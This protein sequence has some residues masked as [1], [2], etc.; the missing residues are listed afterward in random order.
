MECGGCDRRVRCHPGAPDYHEASA[1]PPMPALTPMTWPSTPTR[2]PYQL[3]FYDHMGEGAPPARTPVSMAPQEVAG[4]LRARSLSDSFESPSE[5][6]QLQGHCYAAVDHAWGLQ[7][8]FEPVTPG[9]NLLGSAALRGLCAIA[10]DISKR[11]GEQCHPRL[12]LKNGSESCCP[13]RSLGHLASML[14]GKPCAHLL[15]G[16]AARFAKRLERCAPAF[17]AGELSPRLSARAVENSSSCQYGN[18]VYDALNALIDKQFLD[19]LSPTHTRPRLV[20]INMPVDDPSMLKALHFDV[21]HQLLGA[22][23]HGVR[24]VAYRPGKA[25]TQLFSQVL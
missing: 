6:A 3:R 5:A 25:K 4:N 12:P 18:L 10:D 24:L 1:P 14:A 16:D 7:L 11:I 21:L 23:H 8:V 2:E 17:H 9:V 19:P 13:P 22:D 20:K 15:D